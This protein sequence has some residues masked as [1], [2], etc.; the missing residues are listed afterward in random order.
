METAYQMATELL[1]DRGT[2]VLSKK[3]VARIFNVLDHPPVK[4]VTAIR[5]LLTER[6]VLDG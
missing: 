4:S 6:S 1:A 3:Q 5:K 2:V